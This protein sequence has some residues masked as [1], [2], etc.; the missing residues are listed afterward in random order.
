MRTHPTNP[1]LYLIELSDLQAGSV[2]EV[3]RENLETLH[4]VVTWAEGYLTEPHPDLGRD[5]PVCPFVRRSLDENRFLMT[6][7]HGRPGAEVMR[8]TVLAYRDWFATFDAND[9]REAT[10]NV[11]LVLVPDLATPDEIREMTDGT[12]AALKPE[13]VERGLMVGEFHPLP[14]EKAGLWNPDFRPL[15]S[16]VPLLAIRHMVPSDYAFL[17]DERRFMEAYLD[18]VG[19]EVPKGLQDAVEET[20]EKLGLEAEFAEE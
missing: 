20:A 14:P 11:I 19:D 3:A 18:N 9:E 15:R 12:Q 17:R 5:G 16:P 1:A 10:H 2:P 7:V 6:V 13:F 8:E 4:A